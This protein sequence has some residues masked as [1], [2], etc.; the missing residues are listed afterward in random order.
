[1]YF[2]QQQRIKFCSRIESLTNTTCIRQWRRRDDPWFPLV[3][4]PLFVSLA[5]SFA[6]RVVKTIGRS[7]QLMRLALIIPTAD[8]ATSGTV[9]VQVKQFI[10]TRAIKSDV[11]IRASRWNGQVYLS[12]SSYMYIMHLLGECSLHLSR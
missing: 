7:R 12:A 1:M 8:A 6:L 10:Y 11:R 5:V 3:L 4:F 2:I 9:I